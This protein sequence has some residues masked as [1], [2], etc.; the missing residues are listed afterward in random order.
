LESARPEAR[1]GL[2]DVLGRHAV[3]RSIQ[4]WRVFRARRDVFSRRCQIRGRIH[5]GL[6]PRSRCV[7]AGGRHEVRGRVSR[8]THLGSGTDYVQRPE[9][10]IPAQRRLLPG[11][12]AGAEEALPGRDQPCPEGGTHGTRP[13][14]PGQLGG[15]ASGSCKD[16]FLFYCYV[17]F[18]VVVVQVV[19]FF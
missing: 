8:R 4:Q 5:A 3:R 6:V 18:L 10:R 7:L 14:R 19:L 12:P 17:F 13:V 2:D 9:P 1:H 16:W 15:A 11:L